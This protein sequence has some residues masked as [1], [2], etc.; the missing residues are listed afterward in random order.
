MT[1]RLRFAFVAVTALLS[2]CGDNPPSAGQG[3]LIGSVSQ[4]Y[5]DQAHKMREEAEQR[6]VEKARED[7]FVTGDGGE[8]GDSGDPGPSEE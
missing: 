6:E 5:Q 3:G 8:E 2:A 4:G 7:A 1:T